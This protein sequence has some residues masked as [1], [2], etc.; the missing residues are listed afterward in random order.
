VQAVKQSVNA[1]RRRSDEVLRRLAGMIFEGRLA[2]GA[3]LPSERELSAVLGVSRP[4]L[5]DALNRLEARGFVE[6][7]AKSGS[8]I[9]TAMPR[10]LR[11]PLEEMVDRQVARL[12]DLV[13]IRK[14]LEVWAAGRAA[15][16]PDAN[17]LQNLKARVNALQALARFRTDE[18]FER[19]GA[20][21]MEFHRILARMTRNPI[22]VH[23]IDYLNALIRQSIVMTR[24]LV[25]GNYGEINL[26]SHRRIYE[27]VRDQ[28]A[29]GAQKAMLDHFA[30]SERLLKSARA[31]KPRRRLG[32]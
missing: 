24:E 13:E 14:V 21:D 29:M 19:Y 18:Q 30:L 26:P 3:R 22:Y 28:D 2:P 25:P 15:E 6:R 7:R 11:D 32:P 23:L 27:A 31:G 16:D 4:T 20:A 17:L 9:C 5:R 10:A 12:A 8:F 1:P